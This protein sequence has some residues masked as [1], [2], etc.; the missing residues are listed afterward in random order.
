MKWI[1]IKDKMPESGDCV[2]IYSPSSGVAE[3]AW[4]G[5]KNHFEQWRWNAIITDVTHWRKLP[6]FKK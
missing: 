3:G 1:S 4:I 2:L 5:A 6:K